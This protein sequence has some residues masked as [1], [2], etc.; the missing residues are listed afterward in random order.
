MCPAL[1][2]PLALVS[3]DLNAFDHGTGARQRWFV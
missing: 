1:L 3:D 2:K